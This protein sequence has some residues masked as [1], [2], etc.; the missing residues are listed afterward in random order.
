MALEFLNP[1]LKY[2]PSIKKPDSPLTFKQ[3]LTWTAVIM[4]TY[5][6]LFSIPALGV[7]QVQVQQIFQ[8]AN[9][10]FAAHIGTLITVGISPIVLSSI[11]L[12]LLQGSGALN[13]DLN[14]MEQRGRFQ[15]IQKLIAIIVA[16]VEAIF[17]T[18]TFTNSGLVSPA[19]TGF[20]IF[21]LAVGAII[22]IY[23]DEMMN[24]YGISS[25]INLF[26]A[27]GVAYAII[28]GTVTVL[29]PAAAYQLATAGASAIP[30]ALLAFGPLIVAIL[31]MF[32]SIY[33][34]DV[35]VELPMVFSQFRGIG[36]RLPISLLYASVMPVIFATS[37]IIA[38]TSLAGGALASASASSPVAAFFGYYTPQYS[39][40]GAL[41]NTLSGGLVYLL[42]IETFTESPFPAGYGGVGYSAYFSYLATGTTPLVMPWSGLKPGTDLAANCTL[43]NSCILVPEW[44][45]VIVSTLLLVILCVIFGKFYVEMTGQNPK[46]VAEQLQSVGWQI[47]G[48]RRD[49]RITESIL[50][51][52][53][54]TITVLGSIFVG[55]L[56]AFANLT[57]AVGSGMG[58]L[59]T[60]GI[61]YSLY[62]Q[63]EQQNQ[64][65]Q[66]PML[67]K[68]LS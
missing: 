8:L 7:S 48:F 25:G 51:K 22:V 64:L 33:A 32:I 2:I 29:A 41:T 5:F 66:Y 23:L 60:V 54:P 49:P 56:A 53:I 30:Q 50:N 40:T 57:G 62:Q 10:I 52:Y 42:S 12:Q 61:M 65:E 26:I 43:A 34:Y 58:V 3:K 18:Y 9:V 38:M 44:V 55:L 24:K 59:L 37:L 16:V 14:D 13:I 47:P 11:V 4:I 17:Y 21:Q 15:S 6:A 68:L 35:K 28:A 39:A 20:V 19:F 63:L 27:G 36:G 67:E 45:H 46:N 1:I 31:V